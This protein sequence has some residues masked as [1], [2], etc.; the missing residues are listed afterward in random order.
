MLR[1]S[2]KRLVVICHNDFAPYNLIN[3]GNEF[4]SIIDFDLVGPGPR[5]RDVAYC[6]YWMTPLSQIGIDTHQHALTDIQDGCRRLKLFCSTY[7][8][9]A[10]TSLL[11]MVSEVLKHM[12]DENAMIDC[13]GAEN[14]A[15][16]KANGHL[17][18]WLGE[19]QAFDSYRKD[20]EA[21]L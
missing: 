2:D 9:A 21:K 10:D 4:T 5:I 13:I 12:A 15:R 19:A 11:D 17:T 14:T 1:T 16:L 7:G 20:I 6:A 8:I 18:H 3:D